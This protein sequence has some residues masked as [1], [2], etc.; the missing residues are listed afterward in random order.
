MKIYTLD[1]WYW[2]ILFFS[3]SRHLKSKRSPEAEKKMSFSIGHKQLNRSILN[4]WRFR[5]Q[6][7][8][9]KRNKKFQ[10]SIDGLINFFLFQIQNKFSK[11]RKYQM[12]NITLLFFQT[13]KLLIIYSHITTIS[14]KFAIGYS[15]RLTNT[16]PLLQ[17]IYNSFESS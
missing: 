12:N 9:E 17:R 16:F 6:I 10:I 7:E 3:A 15:F 1:Y 14:I 5:I 8:R 13:T 11:T 2:Q 4:R